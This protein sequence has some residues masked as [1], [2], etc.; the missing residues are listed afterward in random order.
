M[1]PVALVSIDRLG[2]V[3]PWT[4]MHP[5]SV[6]GLVRAI[7]V[8]LASPSLRLSMHPYL[9]FGRSVP[10]RR[11]RSTRGPTRVLARVADTLAEFG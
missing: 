5:A 1:N 4:P 9:P 6:S 11:P 10:R 7:R 8:L 2:W 3:E